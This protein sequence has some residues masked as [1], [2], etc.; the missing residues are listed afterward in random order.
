MDGRLTSTGSP[1]EKDNRSLL[2]GVKLLA[3]AFVFR[4]DEPQY[5]AGRQ[6]GG[7]DGNKKRR[8]VLPLALTSAM[9]AG[10]LR[11]LLYLFQ[12]INNWRNHLRPM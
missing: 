5:T 10:L 4:P 2:H 12:H 8:K 7:T 3:R 1:V 6:Y 9:T 11:G